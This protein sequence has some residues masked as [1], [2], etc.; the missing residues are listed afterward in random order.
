MDGIK[1][2]CK[3]CNNEQVIDKRLEVAYCKYCGNRLPIKDRQETDDKVRIISCPTCAAPI[4]KILTGENGKYS[5]CDYC[6]SKLIIDFKAQQAY[7]IE[8]AK[9]KAHEDFRK[10]LLDKLIEMEE[11]FLNIDECYARQDSLVKDLRAWNASEVNLIKSKIFR[12]YF[13]PGIIALVNWITAVKISSVMFSVLLF[14]TA[15]SLYVFFL[16]RYRRQCKEVAQK[17]DN[18]EDQLM[19]VIDNLIAYNEILGRYPEIKIPQDMKDKETYDCVLGIIADQ[20]IESLAEALSTYRIWKIRDN[21]R[22]MAEARKRRSMERKVRAADSRRGMSVAA[23][24][25]TGVG[26]GLVAKGIIKSLF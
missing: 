7:E 5:I 6:G 16:L 13:L 12:I 2:K 8:K 23:G 9:I 22:A 26:I 17:I 15:V 1:L 4:S 24:I 25:A 11:P 19:V 18:Y 3:Q 20:Q 14:V 21:K 10:S